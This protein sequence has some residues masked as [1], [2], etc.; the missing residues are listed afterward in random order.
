MY[1]HQG[2][3]FE[4]ESRKS[5]VMRRRQPFDV[6]SLR[7]ISGSCFICEFVK[8][9][10]KYG[11]VEIARTDYAVAFMNKYPTLEGYVL[12]APTE[13]LEQVTGDMDETDYLELQK[14]I[15]RMA[16]AVRSVMH[17]ERV[18]ILSLGSQ[19]ANSH[20]HWHI[21][22]IPPGLPLEEQQYH[23]LMHEYGAVEVSNS[24]QE[25]LAERI[26]SAMPG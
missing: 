16:E 6:E 8:G 15:Y 26:R 14:F 18:Y 23:A 12:V 24:E 17:P 9:N 7:P 2:I 19:A 13:H 20:V 3:V 4:F 5:S 10:P 11:H 1:G 22:P 21:A 25:R